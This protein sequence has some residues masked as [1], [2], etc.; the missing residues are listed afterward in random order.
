KLLHRNGMKEGNEP[1]TGELIWLQGNRE[2]AVKLREAPVPK[3]AIDTSFNNIVYEDPKK[4]IE[5]QKPVL[6][7]D[8]YNVEEHG[9][10]EDM[11]FFHTVQTGE[12]LFSIAKKYNVQVEGIKE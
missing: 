9:V 3:Q 7:P 4:N 2:G 10:K 1:A 6:P 5:T 8:Q 12:T 11:A